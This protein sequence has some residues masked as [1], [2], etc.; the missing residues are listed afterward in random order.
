MKHHESDGGK[1]VSKLVFLEKDAIMNVIN[2]LETL[3]DNLAD[4]FDD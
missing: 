4:C 3:C 2:Y 1:G